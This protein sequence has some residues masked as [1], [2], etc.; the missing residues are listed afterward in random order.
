MQFS[1]SLIQIIAFVGEK[2]I[3]KM[4][5]FSLGRVM[6]NL[7]EE[8]YAGL[9]SLKWQHEQKEYRDSLADVILS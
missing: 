5:F 6:R 4:W 1:S 3:E 2:C 9:A 8:K 7:N